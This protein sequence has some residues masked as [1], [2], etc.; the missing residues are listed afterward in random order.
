PDHNVR[1][2]TF[3]TP[4]NATERKR[5]QS[6]VNHHKQSRKAWKNARYTTIHWKFECRSNA[7]SL[8]RGLNYTSVV[9]PKTDFEF[10]SI[11]TI[12]NDTHSTIHND[13]HQATTIPLYN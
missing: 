8:V 4:A 9:W 6:T 2:F 7:K 10:R 13:N 12:D 3:T 1:Y 5:S 11:L